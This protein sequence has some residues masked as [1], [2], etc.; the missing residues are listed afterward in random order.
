MGSR[1]TECEGK[2]LKYYCTRASLNHHLSTKVFFALHISTWERS[3]MYKTHISLMAFTYLLGSSYYVWYLIL[4][5]HN[6]KL[7]FQNFY[8]E[9]NSY[10]QNI[11]S[12]NQ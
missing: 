11:I 9:W 10:C 8:E 6:R 12:N 4:G 7:L 3:K 1:W 5:C 2:D